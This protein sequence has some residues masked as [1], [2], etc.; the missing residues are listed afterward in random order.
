MDSG[1]AIFKGQP[2]Q[3]P[4]DMP[5]PEIP[6]VGAFCLFVGHVIAKPFQ[7]CLQ[8]LILLQKGAKPFLTQ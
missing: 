7:I 4:L 2:F 3:N 5:V 8:I 1:A 6:L